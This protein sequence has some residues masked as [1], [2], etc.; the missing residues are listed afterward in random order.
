M[1]SHQTQG[2]FVTITPFL[3][4]RIDMTHITSILTA[5]QN[6]CGQVIDVFFGQKLFYFLFTHF[7]A[8]NDVGIF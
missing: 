8:L 2:Y 5:I 6:V 4:L 7:R 1:P 3:I